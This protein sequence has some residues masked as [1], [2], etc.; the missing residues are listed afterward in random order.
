[1]PNESFFLERVVDEREADLYMRTILII[2]ARMGSTRLPGKILL[3]LGDTTVLDYS[4]SRCKL[5]ERLEDVIVATS[6]LPADDAVADWCHSKGVTCFRGSQDDVLSRYYE[7]AKLT[8]PDYVIRVTSDCPFIDY[9][10]MNDII[11]CMEAE[12]K[13]I[14]VH[15]QEPA[16]GIWSEIVSFP[17]LEYIHR[18]G[19]ENR[20][21]EHVTYYAYEYPQEFRRHMYTLPEELHH[22]DLRITLDTQ[23]DY[24]MLQRIAGHFQGTAVSTKKV[25]Q[26]LLENPEVA[27]IN[28]HIK[29][30]PV[31]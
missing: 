14:V 28:S 20:H 12:Q 25:V 9:E 5:V 31:V 15:D 26:Y 8:R 13:D 16:R 21:R 30:K 29:Q 22:P 2:Q 4:V 27:A 19:H 1:M 11:D 6:E 18:N 17:A 10:V 24:L 3:P 7:C 23:D